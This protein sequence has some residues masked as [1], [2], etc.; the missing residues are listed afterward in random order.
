MLEAVPAERK[1]IPFGRLSMPDVGT[2]LGVPMKRHSGEAGF[3]I[4]EIMVAAALFALVS[5][6]LFEVVRQSQNVTRHLA[7][8]HTNYLEVRQFAD[9]L[10]AESL[11][12]QAVTASAGCNEVQFYMKD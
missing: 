6:A 11:S 4:I 8:R 1:N 10:R 2:V 5:I 9:R 7:A 12:A 3:T